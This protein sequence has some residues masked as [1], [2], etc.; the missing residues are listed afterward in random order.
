MKILM[1]L[2]LCCSLLAANVVSAATDSRGSRSCR[3]WTEERRQAEGQ[4]KLNKMPILITKS[5][6]LGYLS[7][8]A[9]R[10]SQDLLNGTD[11]E[12]IFLWLDNYCSER[13]QQDLDSAG[14][15]LE[16]ELAK[17]KAG[18]AGR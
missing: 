12:S 3:K 9:S 10:A 11:N 14:L 18:R 17:M 5:W 8:R 6:F 1:I 4:D 7:G 13:P 15:A 2:L 16:L